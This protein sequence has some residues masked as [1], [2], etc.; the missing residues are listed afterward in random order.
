MLVF[1]TI[2]NL[3]HRNIED[4][5]K[6]IDFSK[7]LSSEMGFPET[8][9]N[10]VIPLLKEFEAQGGVVEE[11]F[12]KYIK[13]LLTTAIISRKNYFKSKNVPYSIDSDFLD[14]LFK[15]IRQV[16]SFRQR[17]GTNTPGSNTDTDTG[18]VSVEEQSRMVNR[19]RNWMKE[20]LLK[21][22]TISDSVSR[23]FR[24]NGE[25]IKA[26]M[27]DNIIDYSIK[28]IDRNI[29][30]NPD[31]I[32]MTGLLLDNGI[33]T[34]V[35][36]G[37]RL[38]KNRG[39]SRRVIDFKSYDFRPLVSIRGVFHNVEKLGEKKLELKDQ[40]D[41]D[42]KNGM[43]IRDIALKYNVAEHFVNDVVKQTKSE[44]AHAYFLPNDDQIE[45]IIERQKQ[46]RLKTLELAKNN[47]QWWRKNIKD[48]N[49]N[50]DAHNVAA[51]KKIYIELGKI[52]ITGRGRGTKAFSSHIVYEP[53]DIVPVL[54]GLYVDGRLD[55]MALKDKES[56]IIQEFNPGNKKLFEELRH[57]I[58]QRHNYNVRY[59]I[60]ETFNQWANALIDVAQK[61]GDPVA[62][63]VFLYLINLNPRWRNPSK[64]FYANYTHMIY[65]AM[66]KPVPEDVQKKID[67]YKKAMQGMIRIVMRAIYRVDTLQK[68]SKVLN[69]FANFGNNDKEIDDIIYEAKSLLNLLYDQN[70]LPT[71]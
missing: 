47:P 55:L 36:K 26:D 28:S 22:K 15:K 42:I 18:I 8:F 32:K 11:D 58:K 17:V 59:S 3:K 62:V 25:Y 4:L 63:E 40:I 33:I 13:N 43:N 51:A 64:K 10:R 68:Q 45:Q 61:V 24:N 19:I 70:S 48:D 56:Y 2:Y 9:S 30:A 37:P 27:L 50:T 57:K 21:V 54:D 41:Q 35:D 31:A 66:G 71:L 7:E 6:Y 53:K 12:F 23:V 14:S 60:G 65:D 29:V 16:I 39:I 1:N 44:I 52:D 20:T 67:Q 49:W 38:S 69:K 34:Y 5:E 46:L